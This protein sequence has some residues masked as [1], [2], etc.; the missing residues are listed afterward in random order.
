MLEDYE[1]VLA[2]AARLPAP[3]VTLPEHLL[4]NGD[5]VLN[6]VLAEFGLEGVWS[7]L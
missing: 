1:R 4:T 7:K 5:R 6:A 2:A 3:E